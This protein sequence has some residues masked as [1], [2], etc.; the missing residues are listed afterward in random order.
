MINTKKTS[1]HGFLG[2]KMIVLPKPI[3]DQLKENA[4]SKSFYITDIGYYPKAYGHYV[5]RENGAEEYILIYCTDGFGSIEYM[6]FKIQLSANTFCVLPKNIAHI[7]EAHSKQP[8]SIYW[9]HFNGDLAHGIFKKFQGLSNKNPEVVYTEYRIS[10][11]NQVYRL[12]KNEHALSYLEYANLLGLN[13]ITSLLY[14]DIEKN[15]P[16][17][18][19]TLVEKIKGYLSQNLDKTLKTKD[20]A[21]RFNYSNSYVLNTFKKQT[22]YSLIQFFNLKKTQKA[23]EYLKFTDLSIKE[24]SFKLGFQDPFYFTRLFKKNIG[25]SPLAYRKAN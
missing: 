20:I 24:I 17:H 23:C 2:Q 5:H 19:T 6:N 12:I 8:W 13:F 9:M 1:N 4:L 10:Q 3:Q 16:V 18:A 11:F 7:Y 14:A 15:N 21:E 22:G 25:C